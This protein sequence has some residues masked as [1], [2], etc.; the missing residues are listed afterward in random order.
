M[1]SLGS[2]TVGRDNDEAI[3]TAPAKT[4]VECYA[5]EDRPRGRETAQRRLIGRPPPTPVFA[6]RGFWHYYRRIMK[7]SAR[8]GLEEGSI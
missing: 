7:V 3:P 2:V 8:A 4:F 6:M 5:E 1:I